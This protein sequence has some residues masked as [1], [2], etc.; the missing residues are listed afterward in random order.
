MTDQE[1]MTKL[2]AAHKQHVRGSQSF[3]NVMIRKAQEMQCTDNMAVVRAIYDDFLAWKEK[4]QNKKA[5]FARYM[6]LC[7]DNKAG[8]LK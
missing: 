2:D 6:N 5:D 3:K 4:P 1:L 8:W 7:T